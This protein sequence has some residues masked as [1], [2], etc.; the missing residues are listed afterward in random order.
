MKSTKE[1]S[2][3]LALA[4][5]WQYLTG[6]SSLVHNAKMQVQLENGYENYHNKIKDRFLKFELAITYFL[7]S[8]F[9][10]NLII[11]VSTIKAIHC[12]REN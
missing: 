2:L 10:R 6:C 12:L 8:Q 9:A 7:A 4:Q 3:I 5:K 1:Y 11:I